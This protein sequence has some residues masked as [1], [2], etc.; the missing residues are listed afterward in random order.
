MSWHLYL[1][2]QLKLMS[3]ITLVFFHQ[4]S[5]PTNKMANSSPY[6]LFCLFFLQW[7]QLPDSEKQIYEEKAKKVNEENAIRYAEEQ[8]V[9]EER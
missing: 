4:S 1:L 5:F 9:V 7:R 3:L 6:S 2:I 8:K